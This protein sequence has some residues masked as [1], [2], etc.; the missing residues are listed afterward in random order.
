M[1]IQL[2]LDIFENGEIEIQMWYQH[3][4]KHREGREGRE[5]KINASGSD[6]SADLPAFI[7]FHKNRNKRF[8]I[9]Y[10]EDKKYRKQNG[11]VVLPTFISYRKNGTKLLET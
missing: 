1:I 4:N 5:S 8:E 3:G 11:D 2:V 9:W 6:E 10:H 7:C